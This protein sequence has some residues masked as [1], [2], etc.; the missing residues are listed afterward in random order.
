M[1]LP[2]PFGS[3]VLQDLRL[4]IEAQPSPLLFPWTAPPGD[5]PRLLRSH[6]FVHI[7]FFLLAFQP[8]TPNHFQLYMNSDPNKG[9]VNHSRCSWIQTNT[10]LQSDSNPQKHCFLKKKKKKTSIPQTKTTKNINICYLT[11]MY[12]ASIY[13][14]NIVPFFKKK[15][16]LSVLSQIS[17]MTGNSFFFFFWS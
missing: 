3:P 4:G 1:S 15:I 5:Q 17:P 8:H 12:L 2:C 11:R 10:T 13:R 16:T 7:Q 6:G 9:S 14:Q